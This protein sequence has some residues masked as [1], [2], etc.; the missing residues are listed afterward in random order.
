ME[1]AHE[2]AHL[3]D[4][5]SDSKLWLLWMTTSWLYN[6]FVASFVRCLCQLIFLGYGL[7]LFISYILSVCLFH[8]FS[9]FFSSRRGTIWLESFLLHFFSS[10]TCLRSMSTEQY[11]Q[12]RLIQNLPPLFLK[13]YFASVHFT[14]GRKCITRIEG[15]KR[16]PRINHE[17]Q[18]KVIYQLRWNLCHHFMFNYS[19]WHLISF[20]LV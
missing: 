9:A 11:T 12:W 13:S 19:D 20:V 2:I 1:L 17:C 8:F 18:A 6:G 4:T 14:R 10:V 16:W 15:K 3:D 7:I 5:N